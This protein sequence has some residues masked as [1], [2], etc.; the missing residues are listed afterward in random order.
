M[1]DS[2]TPPGTVATDGTSVEGEKSAVALTSVVAAVALTA[3]KT[4]VGLATGS[5]GLL[6]EAAHSALDL[7]AAVITLLAVRAAARP[8]DGEHPY[9]H[10]KVENLS[11]LAET[12]LLL[13][14]CAWIVYEGVRRLLFHQVEVEA[15]LW[16]FAVIGVS[17]VVDVGRSR[18]LLRVARKTGSQAL[19]ADALH[20]ST[21]VWSSSVVLVGLGF[22]WLAAELRTAWLAKADAVAAL[23]VAVIVIWVSLRLGRRS[24][25]DLLDE[26]PRGLR[27]R[28]AAALRV[29]GVRAVSR[30]RVRRSGPESFVDCTLRVEPGAS[31]ERGHRIADEAESA[32]RR[33]LPGADVVVHVEPDEGPAAAGGEP[34]PAVARRVASGLGLATHSL[35]LA[36]GRDQ[37][38][39]ELH[40]EV[41]GELSVAEAHRQATDLEVALQAA[42]PEVTSVVTHIEPATDPAQPVEAGTTELA[43]VVAHLEAVGRRHGL[44][45]P[46]HEV[47]LSR[48]GGELH[49]A[50]HW[51]MDADAPI[52]EAHRLTEALE[53]SLRERCPQLARVVIHVEPPDAP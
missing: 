8:A 41:P 31:L 36:R 29:D 46:A 10:A 45:R 53:L 43:E 25:G 15:T 27:E 3:M 26:V 39:L 1:L 16:A 17:I 52:A 11:A 42:L 19:E 48:V 44:A 5:L 50:C 6:A 18:A 7:V 37:L 13:A 35:H 9:G 23:V 20:F 4:V 49:L 32:V 33:L 30:V 34:I 22:V 24:V 51:A 28:L 47:S 14:T 2:A 38:S 40:V 12:A 21:D